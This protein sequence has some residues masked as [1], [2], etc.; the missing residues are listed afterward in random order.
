MSQRIIIGLSAALAGLLFVG[1]LS[2]MLPGGWRRLPEDNVRR[3]RNRLRGLRDRWRQ[4]TVT[5][6]HVE[7]RIGA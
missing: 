7:Q 4:G 2:A 6:R 1:V 5:R 3:F